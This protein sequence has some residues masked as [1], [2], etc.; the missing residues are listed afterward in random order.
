MKKTSFLLIGLIV[1]SLALAACNL[2]PQRSAS[3][4]PAVEGDANAVVDGTPG[5]TSELDAALAL[6]ET[7]AASG[8]DLSGLGDEA[9]GAALETTPDSLGEAYYTQEASLTQAA[10]ALDSAPVVTATPTQG[11][12]PTAIPEPD[13][14]GTYT[15]HK[16]EW[17]FCIARRYDVNAQTLMRVNGITSGQVLSVGKNITIPSDIGAFEGERQRRAHGSYVT[18]PGDTFYSIACLFG[19]ISPEVIAVANS[20]G[21]NE[22]LTSGQTIQVP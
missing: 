6:K 19:D 5:S 14:P 22:S 8:G 21:V 18:Q 2:A 12:Q 10:E 16:G 13:A 9:G 15:L 7:E 1:F 3:E 11:A 4:A 20:M 17:L